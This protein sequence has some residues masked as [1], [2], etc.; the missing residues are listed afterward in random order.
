MDYYPGV[1]VSESTRK[2]Q[3]CSDTEASTHAPALSLNLRCREDVAVYLINRRAIIRHHVVDKLRQ[4]GY[5]QSERAS[6]PG[7][8]SQS[9]IGWVEPDDVISSA[10]RRVDLAVLR[11]VIRADSEPR[12]WAY[13]LAIADNVTINKVRASVTRGRIRQRAVLLGGGS[14]R[15]SDEARVALLNRALSDAESIA[16][17]HEAIMV[18]GNELDRELIYWK[19]TGLSLVAIAQIME[20]SP[21]AVRRQWCTLRRKLRATVVAP[22]R[23]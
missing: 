6:H 19:L 22:T 9:H 2:S 4:M 17:V 20:R 23:Q 3:K 13:V 18:T 15:V 5:L 14:V 1:S 21:D 10:M 7:N 8:N 11:Q 16:Q 12:F